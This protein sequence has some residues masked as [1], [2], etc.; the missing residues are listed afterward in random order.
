MS[1]MRSR[2]WNGTNLL[3]FVDFLLI[4]CYFQSNLL[5]FS[6]LVKAELL[7]FDVCILVHN[8]L[9]QL[10][11]KTI[12]FNIDIFI[13]F[14]LQLTCNFAYNGVDISCICK[15]GILTIKIYDFTFRRN[16]KYC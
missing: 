1:S 10:E 13:S 5:D 11:L 2:C 7:M 6:F 3:N 15:L 9:E 16:I 14:K 12:V 8:F 4:F